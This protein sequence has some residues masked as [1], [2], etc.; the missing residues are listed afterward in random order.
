LSWFLI[1]IF[2][3]Y[4]IYIVGLSGFVGII[5]YRLFFLLFL[6][7]AHIFFNFYFS[8]TSE[9]I[10]EWLWEICTTTFFMIIF[11]LIISSFTNHLKPHYISIK[12]I[13]N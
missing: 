6:F 13:P 11:Y 1:N 12:N 7:G 8:L 9:T 3:N 10:L 5:C 4:S 2:T